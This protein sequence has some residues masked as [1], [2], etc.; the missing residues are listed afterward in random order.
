MKRSIRSIVDQLDGITLA[1]DVPEK[2]R[3]IDTTTNKMVSR[4]KRKDREDQL[5]DMMTEMGLGEAKRRR[6]EPNGDDDEVDVCVDVRTASKY[7]DLIGY[8]QPQLLGYYDGGKAPVNGPVVVPSP[9]IRLKI[10]RP[11]L[12]AILETIKERGGKATLPGPSS[13]LSRITSP[14]IEELDD[15]DIMRISTIDDGDTEMG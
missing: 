13:S 15:E 14:A 7:L 11:V 4:V 1:D 2:R 8:K 5:C 12:E 3:R 6:T 9:I 10:K